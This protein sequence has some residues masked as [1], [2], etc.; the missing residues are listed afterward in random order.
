[1]YTTTSKVSDEIIA[2][3]STVFIPVFYAMLSV[4]H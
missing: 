2:S 4:S 3:F 1:M